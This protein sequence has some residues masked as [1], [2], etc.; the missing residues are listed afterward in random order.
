VAPQ[1]QVVE[2]DRTGQTVW[3][4]K[5]PEGTLPWRARRR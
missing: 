3:D 4:Y 5:P 1:A 2:L